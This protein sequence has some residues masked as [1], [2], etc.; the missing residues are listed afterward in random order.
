MINKISDI[1]S[2]LRVFMVELGTDLTA[3]AK[4]EMEAIIKE[5]ESRMPRVAVNHRQRRTAKLAE[6]KVHVSEAYSPPRIHICI[7]LHMYSCICI[8]FPATWSQVSSVMKFQHNES[9]I[10]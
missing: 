3:E 8:R 1:P 10:Q 7:H 5:I 9:V 2:Q 6:S 4:A